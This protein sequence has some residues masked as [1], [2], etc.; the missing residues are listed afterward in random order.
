MSQAA[1][2][3]LPHRQGMTSSD[4][5]VFRIALSMS[6]AISAGAYT[7]GVFDFLMQALAEYERSRDVDKDHRVRIVSLTGASAGGITAA[8]GAVA[9]GYGLPAKTDEGHPGGRDPAAGTVNGVPEFAMVQMSASNGGTIPCLFPSLFDAW[10]VKPA[11]VAAGSAGGGKSTPP[12]DLL[13]GEDL[14]SGKRASSLLNSTVLDGIRE[15]SL[16]PPRYQVTP[17]SYPFLAD[18]FHVYLTLTNLRGIPY[19]LAGQTGN[20][21]HML[22]HSDRIHAVVFGLGGDRRV[23]SAWA[24]KDTADPRL[25]AGTLRTTAGQDPG[26]QSLGNAALATAAFPV[27][28]SARA[29]ETQTSAYAQRRR[30]WPDLGGAV[31]NPA[32]PTGWPSKGSGFSFADVD[33]GLINN[34]PF[35]FA[36][37]TLLDNPE[38]LAARNER[39][40]EWADRAVVMISPFPEGVAF[41]QQDVPEIGLTA[42]VRML[43]PAL[44]QQARF[45]TSELVAALDPLIASRWLIAPRRGGDGSP[46]SS[47]AIACGLLGGFG[48]FLDQ[49]FREHDFQLGRRNCQEFLKD[50]K[51]GFALPG[52]NP[53]FGGHAVDGAARPVIPLRGSTIDEVPLPA[54]P[55]MSRDAFDLLLQRIGRRLRALVPA[56]LPR[57]GV[58]RLDR[59]VVF[60]AALLLRDR[61][62]G[63]ARDI[64]LVDLIRRN[65]IEDGLPESAADS[66][67]NLPPEYREVFAALADPRFDLRTEQGI[68]ATTLLPPE[69]VSAALDVGR[70]LPPGALHKV[71]VSAF[72]AKS[73]AATYTLAL[74]AP[75]GVRTLPVIGPLLR[76]FRE[77]RIG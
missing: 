49:S 65:Q 11:A 37:Y 32:W 60:V 5:P 8:L 10:V 29:V 2:A 19:D 54:W 51:D 35:E 6:G 68:H 7:A 69:T 70:R 21:Y 50:V 17:Q 52:G 47:I 62:L 55:R 23:A 26:W 64:I 12:R 72:P 61:V 36:R 73:G 39:L 22:D 18:P 1:D 56:L 16:R 43:L 71:E 53:L 25:V 66:L 57:R 15:A 9:L 34:D 58:A 30:P 77:F 45:K 31:V 74:R 75:G 28:L 20:G 44:I 67:L 14:G 48:G 27:G 63:V 40:P 42:V 41:S 24:A 59:W 46:V 76:L 38:S 13:S 3:G 4:Q 33:G